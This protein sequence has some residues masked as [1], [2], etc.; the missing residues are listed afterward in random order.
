MVMSSSAVC[1]VSRFKGANLISL[2]SR[3]MYL[4]ISR[5]LETANNL[6]SPEGTL[7]SVQV[8]RSNSNKL[9][10]PTQVLMKLVLEINETLVF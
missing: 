8:V 9:P 7:D 6:D 3:H 2:G 1:S 5:H 4:I 10:H